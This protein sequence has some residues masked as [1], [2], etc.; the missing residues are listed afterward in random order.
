M[1]KG[2]YFRTRYVDSAI[3]AFLSS[4]DA[5][6]SVTNTYRH[7]QSIT[8]MSNS[9][10]LLSKAVLLKKNQSIKGDQH[11][12][13]SAE[14]AVHKLSLTKDLS[15]IE[16]QALE[17]VISLR[18]EVSHS[19]LPELDEDILQHLMYCS[20]KIF[21]SLLR[22]YFSNKSGLT[23]RSFLS[24]SFNETLTYADGIDLLLKKYKS[25]NSDAKKLIWLLERGIRYSGS[26]YIKQDEF[27]RSFLKSKKR[28]L[29]RLK[30]GEY[31]K[32]SEQLKLV[33]IQAPKGYT[34]DIRISKNKFNDTEALPVMV[35]KTDVVVDYPYLTFQLA[36]KLG[37]SVSFTARMIKNLGIKDNGE[38]HQS[39]PAGKNSKIQRYSESAFF[40]LKSHLEKIP[41][42]S[43]FI[44][45]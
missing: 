29:D 32:N 9:I 33:L 26:T 27:E 25:K 6:N 3:R 23:Q 38:Y 16:T 15:E 13:I 12:T 19:Y 11:T 44:K 22:K 35:K 36:D 14:R 34:A 31:I 28:I 8:L 1:A 18:N 17:Q 37:K 30:I 24:I 20:Y 42:Y 2:I 41:D 10:E 7:E 21:N 39:I 43:P 4:V 45:G 5:Y 40:H